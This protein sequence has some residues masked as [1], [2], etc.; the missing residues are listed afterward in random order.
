MKKIFIIASERSGTNLLRTLLGNHH[1]IVAPIAPHFLNTFY[2]ILRYY[3]FLK[4][5]KQCKLLIKDAIALANHPYHNWQLNTSE[6][7]IY[8]KYQPNSLVSIIDALYQEKAT[9]LNKNNYVSKG[10][11]NFNF[12]AL[13]KQELTNVKFIYLYRDPRDKV[14]S[15]LRKPLFM[16]TPFQVINRWNE[17]QNKCITL[18]K[19]Y[20]EDVFMLKYEDLIKNTEKEMSKLLNFFNLDIDPS[21]FNTNKNNKEAKRNEFWKNLDKAII[22]D[23]DKKYKSQLLEK[24][25]LIIESIAKENMK[26]LGYSLDTTADWNKSMSLIFRISEVLK[27]K[28]STKKNKNFYLKEMAILKDKHTLIK[29]IKA[30]IKKNCEND[31]N[32]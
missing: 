2:P 30:N 19:I 4:E 10:I 1:D 26:V 8:E 3:G 22:K 9:S 15:S 25:I 12:V 11:H 17:E 13:I 29:Q 21:C 24:D 18:S 28:L 7:K 32:H 23:N 5:K 6:K 14:A 20:Q 16:H 31:T 27:I